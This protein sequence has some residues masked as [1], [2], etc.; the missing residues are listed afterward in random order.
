MDNKENGAATQHMLVTFKTDAWSNITVF[1]DV[2]FQLL[3]MMGHSRRVPGVI[4]AS[5]VPEA[6]K[7]L[8]AAVDNVPEPEEVQGDDDD[9]EQDVSLKNRAFPVIELLSSAQDGKHNVMWDWR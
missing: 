2:A 1:K 3:K 7:R 5:D 8:R 6:L 4:M 9:N